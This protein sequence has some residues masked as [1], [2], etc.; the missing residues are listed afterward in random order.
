M[1]PT[2]FRSSESPGVPGPLCQ[3][4]RMAL[5]GVA[6]EAVEH[7]L[8][9]GNR[10]AVD[11]MHFGPALRELRAT[12]VT[13]R[14]NGKLRGCTGMLEAV[15]PLVAD[16]AWN[17]FSTAFRDP[18]F[19]PLRAEELHGLDLHISVLTTPER[20]VFG[21]EEDLLA[22]L[23]PGIDGLILEE[24]KRRATFLPAVWEQLSD[25]RSF[26]RE[27]KVKAGFPGDHWSERL[28][29]SRY[30]VESIP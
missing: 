22:Q 20:L 17:A 15:R 24:G 25:S 1:G 8:R 6:R 9:T 4:D 27:L 16:V 11:P 18:R 12:F 21:S 14:L 10:L 5:L 7:G 26:L 29:A 13:A 2:P 3:P 28:R 19:A 23:Q 30:T